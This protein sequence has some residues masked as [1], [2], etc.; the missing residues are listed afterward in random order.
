MKPATR[1]RPPAVA[2]TFYP[3][4]PDVLASTVDA[5]LADATAPASRPRALLAPHAGYRY[6]GA[7]AARAFAPLAPGWFDTAIIVGPSHVETFDFTAVYDGDAFATPLGEVA[8]DRD[9]AGALCNTGASIRLATRGHAS[10]TRRGEHAIEV[11]LPFLQRR[12]PALRIVAVTKGSQTP[13]ACE[14]LA[15]A[16]N[17][18]ADRTRT[19]VIASSDL[20]HFHGY[21]D[22]VRLDSVFCE[23]FTAMNAGALLAAL[24]QGRCE[25]CGG[26]PAAVAMLTAS[27]GSATLLGRANSGDVTGERESVVGYA[28]ARIV[29]ESAS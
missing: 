4:N 25:A 9:L 7:T 19:L 1:I 26:G 21:D 24:A 13:L 22:A 5:L 27:G 18:H 6:S 12:A 14:A 3:A 8:V 2:G 15:D 11:M 29:A 17:T 20:S 16:I 23:L 28:A 10:D